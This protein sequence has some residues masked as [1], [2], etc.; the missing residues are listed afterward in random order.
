MSEA[1]KPFKVSPHGLAM[2]RDFEGVRH[3]AYTDSVGVWTIGC[4]HTRDVHPGD[5]IDDATVDRYL[6]EDLDWVERVLNAC[7]DVP[8]TQNQVDALASFIFNLGGNAFRKSTLLK[9]LNRGDYDG[10]GDELLRWNKA[11]GHVLKGLVRRREKER[12]VFMT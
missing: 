4:G 5:T 1:N 12:E 3:T 9:K 2:I 6:L 8:L 11:S 7:V 10:A